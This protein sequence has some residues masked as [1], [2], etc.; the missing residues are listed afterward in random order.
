MWRFLL[1]QK[2]DLDGGKSW[3]VSNGP[4]FVAKRWR[5]L[6]FTFT[7]T[8]PKGRSRLRWTR[9]HTSRRLNAVEAA[10]GRPMVPTLTGHGDD[11]KR[12]RTTALFVGHPLGDVHPEG[13]RDIQKL[14][15]IFAKVILP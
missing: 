4:D 1:R 8:R 2:I 15:L 6:A 5:S 11:Y 12:H 9:N 3:C 14:Y 7:L 13:P 10:R